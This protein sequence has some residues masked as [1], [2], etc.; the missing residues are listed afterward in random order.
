VSA[1]TR[2]KFCG[3]TRERDAACA[4]ALGVD[5][6]GFVFTRRSRRFV[7]PQIAA[8]IR[9]TLPPFVCTVALFMDDEPAWIETVLRSFRADRLQFH[10]GES[11]AFC[12]G[13]AQP[14]LKAVAMAT[15]ADV[16]AYFATYASAAGFVL[17]AHATG[18]A[19]G[20]GQRF[21]WA[22]ARG[23]SRPILL[24]GGLAPDTVGA[25]IAQ[26]RPHAV[27]VSS[28]IEITPGVKDDAKMRAFVA[29][30]RAADSE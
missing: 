17:D 10:G 20:T 28:G 13:F 4:V 30:V 2:I 21:D 6:L 25:A 7:D 26:T 11:A 5:A 22:R 29:A 19:G 8:A 1:R 24:A 27:D 18:E 14:Y 23:L 12:E 16:E 9:A 3:I 15:I